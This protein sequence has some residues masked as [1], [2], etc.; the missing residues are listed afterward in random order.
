MLKVTQLT[1]TRGDRYDKFRELSDALMTV[2]PSDADLEV[3]VSSPK[4][5][6]PVFHGLICVPYAY[7]LD[8]PLPTSRELF[9]R[10][11]P[12]SHPV[13]IARSLLTLVVFLQSFCQ[14][15][16]DA[17]ADQLSV[18]IRE[19]MIRAF[20]T[21]IRLVTS[22]DELVGTVEG[23]EC[24]MLECIYQNNAGYLRL[25]CLAIRRALTT[26]Q[27]IGLNRGAQSPL[28][29]V[30]DLET[31]N[32]VK[33]DHMWFRILQTDR[34]LSL[35]L[36]MPQGTPENAFAGPDVADCADS[37]KVERG[38]AIAA[39]RIIE[40]NASKMHDPKL[41]REVDELLLKG[42]NLM[43]PQWWLMP[44]LT[45]PC[46][47]QRA[48]L[49]ET[50]RFMTQIAHY[51]LL[52]RLH[53][54]YLLRRS[55]GGEYDYNKMTAVTASR[56]LLTR[57]LVF[58]DALPPTGTFCRGIDFLA[59]G[60]STVICLGHIDARLSRDSNGEGGT[61][62]T[63][64]NYLAHY[65][66][67]DRGMMERTLARFKSVAEI[68]SDPI[69]VKIYDGM[70]SLLAV[71]ADLASGMAFKADPE[72]RENGETDGFGCAGQ[73]DATGD[74]LAIHIPQI[75]TIKIRS[76]SQTGSLQSSPSVAEEVKPPNTQHTPAEGFSDSFPPDGI[77][78]P[79]AAPEHP[80]GSEQFP[81]DPWTM[82]HSGSFS[83]DFGA[84]QSFTGTA[85]GFYVGDE[86][87]LQGVDTAFFDSLFLQA[88]EF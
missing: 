77:S 38:L 4:G 50:N 58:R 41:T 67:S 20:E 32:R 64:F 53:L 3:I 66:V 73:P 71:E 61:S 12:K 13:L 57:F 5:T 24:I 36:G 23:V 69:A 34:Y 11:D 25:A 19:M 1:A 76:Q 10:P 70:K 80:G 26:A 47:D 7:V 17:I 59:F 65:R 29:R 85:P 84:A 72:Y 68:T 8:E 63:V 44:D 78:Q 83:F 49:R 14:P 75:G 86:W 62:S 15:E 51:T 48:V 33:P 22:N 88:N 31:R 37:E 30:L 27:M 56:E 45:A 2:W 52:E 18:D 9:K 60:A 42:A 87:S 6:A 81:A 35:Q 43:T 28:L 54:P 74:G 55:V 46:E 79:F 21:A 82:G 40:R 39:G 16:A